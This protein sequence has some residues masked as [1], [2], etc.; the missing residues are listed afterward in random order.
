MIQ[1][2]FICNRKSYCPATNSEEDS[3][4]FPTP[5]ISHERVY[6]VSLT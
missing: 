6:N 3:A 1:I 2:D 4:K 5:T